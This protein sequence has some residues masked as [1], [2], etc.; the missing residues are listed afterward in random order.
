M[1][2]TLGCVAQPGTSRNVRTGAWRT[3]QKPHFIHL[4]CT[5]CELCA[6]AC[7]DGCIYGYGRNTYFADYDYCKGCGVCATVCPVDDIEMVPEEIPIRV[8]EEGV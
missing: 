1:K 2:M 3:G 7:P 5:A 4:K 8:C 6:L